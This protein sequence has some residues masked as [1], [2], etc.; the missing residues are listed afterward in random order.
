MWES[1]LSERNGR[2]MKIMPQNGK[3]LSLVRAPVC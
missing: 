3:I 1:I 2:A